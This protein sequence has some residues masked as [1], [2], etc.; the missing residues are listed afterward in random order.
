MMKRLLLP[1]LL[2]LAIHAQVFVEPLPKPGVQPQTVVS[3]DG[4]VHLV[5]LLGDPM[6]CDVRHTTRRAEGGGWTAPVT[7]NSEPHSAIAT[8]A[9]RGAQIA[10]GR[11]DSV[12]VIWNGNSGGKK[13]LMMRAPLLHARLQPG[14]K[15]FSTQQNLMGNTTALDG[16]AAIAADGRGRV[17][18]VWH[19]AP[20]GAAGEAA[21]LV[22]ARHSA[23]DGRTF[24]DPQPLNEEKPGICACCSLRAHLAADGTLTVLYRGAP[25]PASR[26]MIL[27]TRKAG[28]SMLTPLDDWRVPMCPMSSASLLPAGPSLR[29][30]WE[31]DGQILT[32]L[33]D[34]PS[35]AAQ[36]VGPKNARHPALAQNA[37]GQTLIASVIGSGWAKAGTLHRDLLDDQ[38]RVTDSGDGVQKLPVWSFAAAYACPDGS[39]VILH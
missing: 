7:V 29:A 19:A 37:K 14:A 5:Y 20:A 2:P 22:Y 38:G 12:Q 21:R 35:T 1:L 24:S 32:G 8:G 26:G 10:L 23:D 31:N 18:V 39:F 3:A 9:I 4:V 17:C 16:G 13:D 30:A 36:K 15:A 25:A 28:R 33:L 27:L 11:D 34:A 6:A